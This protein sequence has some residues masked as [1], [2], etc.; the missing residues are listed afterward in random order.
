MI[1]DLASDLLIPLSQP[2]L[3]RYMLYVFISTDLDVCVPKCYKML[4]QLRIP[5]IPDT[6]NDPKL[7]S[8][9][10]WSVLMHSNI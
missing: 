2:N 7:A 9:D 8:N 6:Y 1:I 4:Y 5:S 3:F 10:V